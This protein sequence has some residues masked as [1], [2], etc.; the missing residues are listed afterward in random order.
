[1]TGLE[2]RLG[3]GDAVVIGLGAM[4][5]AGVFSAIGPAAGAA[6]TALL[7]GLVVAALVA[8]CNAASSAQL[9]AQY[10]ESGGTYVYGRQ[11]LGRGG[12]SRRVSASSSARPPRAPRWR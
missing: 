3:T 11:R 1:M 7:V 4:I 5:G 2:R 9:A 10:P 6:G 8:Y 12:G